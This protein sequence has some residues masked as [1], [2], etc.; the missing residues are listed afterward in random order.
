MARQSYSTLVQL[1]RGSS[2]VVDFATFRYMSWT[3]FRGESSV[4]VDRLELPYPRHGLARMRAQDAE[5]GTWRRDHASDVLRSAPPIGDPLLAERVERLQLT[6]VTHRVDHIPCPCYTAADAKD[7][8]DALA[9]HAY[10][11]VFILEPAHWHTQN[12][13]GEPLAR[14]QCSTSLPYRHEACVKDELDRLQR[15]KSGMN[16]LK[17]SFSDARNFTPAA[18]FWRLLRAASGKTRYVVI[19]CP[20]EN[21]PPKPAARHRLLSKW[22]ANLVHGWA[23]TQWTH[24]DWAN[25]TEAT[26]PMTTKG[27]WHYACALRP[28]EAWIFSPPMEKLYVKTRVNGDCFEAGST[29]LWQRLVLPH[30]E[31]YAEDRYA[32]FFPTAFN[33]TSGATTAAAPA[34]PP[35]LVVAG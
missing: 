9:A 27:E 32:H 21:V 4:S 20:Q 8:T 17:D 12:M 31:K 15:F 25:H 5:N 22:V 29:E 26:L 19:S 28:H 23:S 18:D 2:D 13:C 10:D 16:I 33:D 3:R 35:I 1:L 30:I 6:P 14:G 7:L 24:I 34:S 11:L